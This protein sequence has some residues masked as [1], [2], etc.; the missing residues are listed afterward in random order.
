ML[1]SICGILG[2]RWQRQLSLSQLLVI[3][4][5]YFSGNINIDDLLI[6]VVI[7]IS[8]FTSQLKGF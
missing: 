5:F 6:T 3:F 2:L 1:Y 4:S 7:R 8:T